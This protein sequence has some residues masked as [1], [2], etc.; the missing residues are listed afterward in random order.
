[1]ELGKF[2]KAKAT[3]GHEAH[4]LIRSHGDEEMIGEEKLIDTRVLNRMIYEQQFRMEEI[5]IR[6]N[7]KYAVTDMSLC[8]TRD[9]S[10]PIS[11]FPR[12][13]HAAKSTYTRKSTCSPELTTLVTDTEQQT[14][15]Y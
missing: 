14:A 4:F 13:L 11:G 10:F 8:F 7:S 5:R 3:A 12:G 6:R 9:T 2:I 15:T 1:M